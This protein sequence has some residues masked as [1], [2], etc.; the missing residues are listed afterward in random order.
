MNPQRTE[1]RQP[2]ALRIADDI[3]IR[4]E[5]GDLREGDSIP[6]MVELMTTYHCSSTTA[7]SAVALL[8]T[9]GLVTGGRGKAPLVR[10]APARVE[11]SNDRH[12]FEKDLVLASEEVRRSRGLAEDDLNSSLDKLHFEASYSFV[13]A[14]LG[15]A[16]AFGIP[17][18]SEL[19]RREFTHKD[20]KNGTLAA[21]STSWLLAEFTKQN[22]DIA[23]PDPRKKAWAGGTMHQ[24]YTVGVEVDRVI[25]HVTAAMPT[26]VESQ[27]WN[28]SDGTPIIWVRRVSIDT[29]DRVVEVSDAQYPADRT[30]LTFHSQLERW[31]R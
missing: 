11:R 10:A 9:Q 6:T 18:G 24:L 29:T 22:P 30:M 26:T 7:R 27:A 3:R 20:K 15:L 28:L 31:E 23:D 2:V 4:I 5:S 13:P 1:A 16:D 12:Q 8:K 19:F 17:E 21:W 25:D 14:D